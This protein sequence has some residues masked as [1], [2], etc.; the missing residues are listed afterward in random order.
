MPDHLAARW[1]D[2]QAGKPGLPITAQQ[3]R[4]CRLP[5]VKEL[6]LDAMLPGGALVEQG[7]AQPD[8]SAQLLDVRGWDPGL[9]RA[10]RLQQLPQQA[11]IGPVG[12]GATL[13]ATQSA[14]VCRLGEVCLDAAGLQLFDDEP[15]AGG[16][17][18]CEGGLWSWNRCSQSSPAQ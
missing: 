12:L 5:V 17:L 11:G 16:G 1:A 9:R 10:A 14:G 3:A 8:Q 7:L 15:P 13:T 18:Q 4:L 6:R 2:L